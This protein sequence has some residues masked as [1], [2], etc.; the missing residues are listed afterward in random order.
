MI[1][2]PKETP[3]GPDVNVDGD[4]ADHV[5][6]IFEK[7]CERARQFGIQ[8][9]TYMLTKGVIK[10]IIPAVASTNAVIS[11]VSVLETMKVLT[12]CYAPIKNYMMFN[13]SQGVYTYVF[14]AEKKDECPACSTKPINISFASSATLREVIEHMKDDP[15]LQLKNPGVTTMVGDRNKTLYLPNIP[16]LELQTRCNLE[17]TMDQ[18]EVKH[19][20]I[21]TVTDVT[22]PKHISFKFLLSS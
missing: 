2:W 3:F 13:D 19:E 9:V 16:H 18:L 7:S 8:G 5:S 10:H 22:S 11:A 12:Y 1:Q 20:Q 15:A 17:M 14:E 21:L 6:W 4:D